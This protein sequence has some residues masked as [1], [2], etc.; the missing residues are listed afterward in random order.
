ML[1]IWILYL[2]KIMVSA[3]QEYEITHQNQQI[4]EHRLAAG[5]SGRNSYLLSTFGAKYWKYCVSQ[6]S[7]ANSIPLHAGVIS[8]KATRADHKS[9]MLCLSRDNIK[10]T[11]ER[12]KIKGHVFFI[13]KIKTDLHGALGLTNKA[14]CFYITTKPPGQYI[15]AL[16]M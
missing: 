14:S 16:K 15:L 11:C 1:G 9:L 13:S 8:Y 4:G 3:V 10:A 2:L 12:V 6:G 5:Q 7:T